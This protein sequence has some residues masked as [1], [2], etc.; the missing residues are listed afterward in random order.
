MNFLNFDLTRSTLVA[1]ALMA[2]PG[3]QAIELESSFES[4]S[5]LRRQSDQLDSFNSPWFW[6]T[7]NADAPP[8]PGLSAI[9]ANVPVNET[10]EQ[11]FDAL[12]DSLKMPRSWREDNVDKPTSDCLRWSKE[13]LGLLAT[14]YGIIPYKVAYS[15]EGGVFAAYQNVNNDM[16]LNLEIDNDLDVVA[17]LSDGIRVTNSE[18]L[19]TENERDII[20][21]FLA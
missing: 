11:H 7:K 10:F 18:I 6:I 8:E 4:E 14:K 16:I 20:N 19:E 3:L 9:T 12:L 17:V 1:G 13:I 5:C 2:T 21:A 15:K